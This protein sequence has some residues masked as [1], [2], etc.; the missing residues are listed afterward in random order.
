MDADV[1]TEDF[2]MLYEDP[3]KQKVL[4]AVN[5]VKELQEQD[6]LVKVASHDPPRGPQLYC[7]GENPAAWGPDIVFFALVLLRGPT[8]F[9][10][11]SWRS[12]GGGKLSWKDCK[13]RVWSEP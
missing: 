11:S 2:S 10:Y 8:V 13:G 4:L 7:T 5:T 9:C 6:P 1:F 12:G 3:G